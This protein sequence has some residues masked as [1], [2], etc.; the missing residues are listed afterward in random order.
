MALLL[1]VMVLLWIGTEIG[2]NDDRV[3]RFRR[4]ACEAVL[5]A[6]RPFSVGSIPLSYRIIWTQQA[7]L[8]GAACYILMGRNSIYFR[9]IRLNPAI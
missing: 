7:A 5:L 1:Q 9:R 8:F 6:G 2:Y 3:V 4:I